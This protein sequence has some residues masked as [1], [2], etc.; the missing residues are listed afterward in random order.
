MLVGHHQNHV[1]ERGNH[2]LKWCLWLCTDTNLKIGD[3]GDVKGGTEGKRREREGGTGKEREG[4]GK[5]SMREGEG[6]EG[7]GKR[8]G[9]GGIDYSIVFSYPLPV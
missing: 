3:E 2:L 8:K 4:R 1:H 7:K 5:G 6:R 9:K